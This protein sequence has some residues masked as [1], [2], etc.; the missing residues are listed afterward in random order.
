MAASAPT[1]PRSPHPSRGRAVHQRR[2]RAAPVPCC[3]TNWRTAAP[4]VAQTGAAHTLLIHLVALTICSSG[5]AGPGRPLS[6]A[7]RGGRLGRAA[8]DAGGAGIDA[9]DRRQRC[10]SPRIHSLPSPVSGS[11]NLRSMPNR[12]CGQAARRGQEQRRSGGGGGGG[13]GGG[14]LVGDAV[15]IAQ[16]R[17]VR[18]LPSSAAVLV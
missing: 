1:R 15:P 12:S 9:D 5:R 11:N 6:H 18:V 17:H 10:P 14:S 4:A 2:G 7:P 13:G 8:R 3:G 16:L